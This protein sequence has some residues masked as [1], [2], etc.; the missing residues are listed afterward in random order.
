MPYAL[1][2]ETSDLWSVDLQ[3]LKQ[4]PVANE[5]A[6]EYWPDVSPDGRNIAYQFVSQ[7]DRVFGGTLMVVLARC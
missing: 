1:V 4:S 6:S 5:V 3:S 7:V 2:S